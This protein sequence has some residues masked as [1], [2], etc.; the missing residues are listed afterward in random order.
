MGKIK[1]FMDGKKTFTG[2][3]VAVLGILGIGD[4]ITEGEA[5]E[6]INIIFTFAGIIE[7]AWGRYA[8][9]KDLRAKKQL[10]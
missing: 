4:I 6:I 10:I 3:F 9:R 7:T 5:A 2:L 8:A 1:K